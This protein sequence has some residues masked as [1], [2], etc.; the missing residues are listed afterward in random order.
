[1]KLASY[2]ILA[3]VILGFA[4]K[5]ARADLANSTIN[6]SITLEGSDDNGFYTVNVFTG[7]ISVGS[8]YS[9]TYSFF[10]Q[11]TFGGF[12][13]ASNQLTGT[14][15]LSITGS[16]ISVTFNGQAQPVELIASFTNLPPTVTS[17]TEL[18]SGFL[19]GVALPFPN[20][21]TA[22]SLNMSAF[23]FGFQ[24]GTLTNQTDILTFGSAAPTP[25][26]SSL[27]LT[28][29]GLFGMMGLAWGKIRNQA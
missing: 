16:S 14:I 10:R 17:A 22:T 23:Y 29:T 1:M 2:C 6:A 27:L 26:P 13:T 11:D 15:S 18:D 28:A 24:P 8:G 19:S 25:E 4:P 9:N 12:A 5:A 3:A 21:F 20:S 7:A